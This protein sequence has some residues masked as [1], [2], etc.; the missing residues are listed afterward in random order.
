MGN[1]VNSAKDTLTP[2]K[3]RSSNAIDE[4]QH[5]NKSHSSQKEGLYSQE[6]LFENFESKYL[7]KQRHLNIR[8]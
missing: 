7:N 2:K 8:V 5:Q 6:K 1:Q 4:V 3:T